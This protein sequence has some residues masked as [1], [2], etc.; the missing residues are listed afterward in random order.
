VTLVPTGVAVSV[1]IVVV[2]RTVSPVTG[3]VMLTE[4][5][6]LLTCRVMVAEVVALPAT[7]VAMPRRS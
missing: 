7:S 4:A 6:P 2:P 3:A 1:V 5:T